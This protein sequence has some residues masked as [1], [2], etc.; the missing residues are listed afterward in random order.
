MNKKPIEKPK[1]VIDES[2]IDWSTF[3][4]DWAKLYY[5]ND[6]TPLELNKP[7][8]PNELMETLRKIK[9]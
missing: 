4:D 5:G 7:L 8:S 2:N 3:G 9:D 6:K 1:E